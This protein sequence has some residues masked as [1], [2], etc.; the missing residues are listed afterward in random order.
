MGNQTLPRPSA[1]NLE[2][3]VFTVKELSEKL[4]LDRHVI[5][6]LFVKEHGVRDL[7]LI[8][9][10]VGQRKNHTLRIPQSAVNR[11][12]SRMTN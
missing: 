9:P 5:V 6:R 2:E 3:P 8:R 1:F 7:S 4:K 10:K 11:V 12:L